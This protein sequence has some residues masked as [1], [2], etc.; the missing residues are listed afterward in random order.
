M[1]RFNSAC[2]PAVDL[3]AADFA[4]TLEGND[5][6]IWHAYVRMEVPASMVAKKLGVYRDAVYERASELKAHF[7]EFMESRV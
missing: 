7:K 1:T 3:A 6:T 5:R 4:E 2:D